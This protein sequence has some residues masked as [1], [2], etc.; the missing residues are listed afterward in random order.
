MIIAEIGGTC[1]QNNETHHAEMRAL[2]SAKLRGEIPDIIV[3]YGLDKDGNFTNGRPCM[4]CL[5]GA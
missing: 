3:V 4:Y 1:Y 5:K 2:K